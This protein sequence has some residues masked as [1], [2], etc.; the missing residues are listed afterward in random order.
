[1]FLSPLFLIGGLVA[2]TLPVLLHLLQKRRSVTIPFPTLR[3]LKL[4]EQ[5]SSRRMHFENLLLWLLRTLIMLLLG[6]AFAMPVLRSQGLAWL[7]RAP[8]D[9]AIVVDAS[10][11][12]GYQAGR[13][14]VWDK[15]LETATTIINGLDEK[16]RYCLYL[17]GEQPE[18]L[19]AEPVGDRE[20]GLQFL[21]AATLKRSTSRLAPAIKAATS[22]LEREQKGRE[23]EVYVLT[24]GQAAPWRYT[25][26]NQE[27]EPAPAEEEA[28]KAGKKTSQFVALLG[29]PAPV[30]LSPISLE[31]KPPLVLRDAPARI[32]VSALH[33]GP[34]R[35]SIV[36]LFI[37]EEEIG[38]RTLRLTGEGSAE[39][40]F[41]MPPRAPGTYPARVETPEDGLEFDNAFHFLVR[42]RDSLPVLCVGTEEDTLYLR[43]ALRTSMY[44][45]LEPERVEGDALAERPLHDIAVIFLCNALPLSGQA[46]APLEEYVRAGGLLVLFPGERAAQG[47]YLS[48]TTLPLEGIAMK[49]LA[50]PERGRTLTWPSDDHALLN[51]FR[52]RNQGADL[53]RSGPPFPPRT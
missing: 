44:G 21:K 52:R 11:S 2:A 45:G 14:T 43:T 28:P 16:D 25:A 49:D 22:A 46:L 19:I 15:A 4:A 6:A 30:N 31:M 29:P 17:A 36:R 18:A 47:D 48:W 13:E 39:V 7:G 33:N 3:F 50:G 37:G 9:V 38:R 23:R 51:P 27:S 24:D 1:M 40:E 41:T 42:V 34:E 10:Y 12:M 5:K 53:T 32:K 20:Q 8:R 26:G 35:E